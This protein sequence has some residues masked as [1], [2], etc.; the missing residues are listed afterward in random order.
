MQSTNSL[1]LLAMVA[2]TTGAIH[3][4][5][6]ATATID[7]NN[8]HQKI[9]GFGVCSAWNGTLAS[10]VVSGLWDTTKGAG[11]SLHRVMIDRD[12]LGSD[13]TNNAVAASKYGVKVW[14]TPWYCKNGVSKDGSDTLYEKDYQE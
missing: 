13:E 5:R 9:S 12:G 14:G 7:V 2:A 8:W 11:L 6:A 4:A 1:R 3:Q 10:D